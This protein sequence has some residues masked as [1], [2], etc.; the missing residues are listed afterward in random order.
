MPS[1]PYM[2]LF[3]FVVS[4]K[5][6]RC[7]LKTQP[8]NRD[9]KLIFRGSG[10]K[11]GSI[12]TSICRFSGTGECWC[13]PHAADLCLRLER[14]WDGPGLLSCSPPK[15][16]APAGGGGGHLHTGLGAAVGRSARGSC[17]HRGRPPHW[18]GCWSRCRSASHS[19]SLGSASGL[20]FYR[21]GRKRT[22][23]STK[24]K[25]TVL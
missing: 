23:A 13:F 18:R 21:T 16:A 7:I 4:C 19:G 8:N 11:I 2:C 25:Q 9:C 14:G 22:L 24:G 3:I 17:C 5:R 20:G 12:D 15:R 1:S 10:H 6:R